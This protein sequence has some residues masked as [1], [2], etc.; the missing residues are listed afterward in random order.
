MS[1][2]EHSTPIDER[3]F[4][5][6]IVDM[7]EGV[8]HGL[9]AVLHHM[10]PNAEIVWAD[11]R[12]TAHYVVQRK[13]F[14]AIAVLTCRLF[15]WGAFADLL[16]QSQPETPVIFGS[17]NQNMADEATQL[18]AVAFLHKPFDAVE[19]EKALAGA[20]GLVS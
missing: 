6:L 1:P 5:L 17:A 2:S 8:V 4:T 7:N 10:L 3:P 13:R 11:N 15:E 19:F 16:H 9:E 12:Q 14:D 20:L 18:G